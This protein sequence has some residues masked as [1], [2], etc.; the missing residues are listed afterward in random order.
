MKHSAIGIFLTLAP[1]LMNAQWKRT[2]GLPGGFVNGF[3]AAGDTIVTLTGQLYLTVDRGDNWMPLP[4]TPGDFASEVAYYEGE[5]LLKSYDHRQSE[6]YLWRSADFGVTWTFVQLADTMRAYHFFKLWDKIYTADNQGMF[7]TT[8][9]GTSWMQTT[10][11]PINQCTV[12]RNRITAYSFSSVIQSLDGGFEWDT[13]IQM[14]GVNIRSMIQ[15]GDT[16]L[17]FASLPAP[18]MWVTIDNGSTWNF[19]PNHQFSSLYDIFWHNQSLV[20]VSSNKMFRSFDLGASW[21]LEYEGLT[22]NPLYSGISAGG[23]T[24]LLGA[25][26]TGIQRRVG[27][28]KPWK[29]A[30]KGVN[31]AYPVAFFS[32]DS[33][34][35]AAFATGLWKLDQDGLNWNREPI[36]LPILLGHYMGAYDYIEQDG[37]KIIIYG[38]QIWVKPPGADWQLSIIEPTHSSSF[39]KLEYVSGGIVAF[40]NDWASRSSNRG[41][42]FSNIAPFFNQQY[43][44]GNNTWVDDNNLY[45]FDY[46]NKLFRSGNGGESWEYVTT[47][48]VEGQFPSPG[49]KP[50]AWIRKNTVLIKDGGVAARHVLFSP[51]LGLTW[52]Y[53]NLQTGD[54]P[55]GETRLWD[56]QECNGWLLLSTNNGIYVSNDSG[57]TWYDWSEG[58][59]SKLIG[60][61]LAH[62]GYVWAGLLKYGIWKRPV[63]E[64]NTVVNTDMP[65]LVVD[66][67][68]LYP[69]PGDGNTLYLT[70]PE[71]GIAQI[72]DNLGHLI[73]EKPVSEG[74]TRWDLPSLSLRPGSYFAVLLGQKQRYISL[75]MVTS[76]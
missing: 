67:L 58:L 9:N 37:Y 20:N 15:Q 49:P 74:I 17:L 36:D 34:L 41:L 68:A 32:S 43:L 28:N 22:G 63:S 24:I 48:P 30:N 31:N 3:T 33:A 59:D 76:G 61:I 35:Y 69:N 25:A 23:D 73:C 1:L 2:N 26:Y 38:G 60:P 45:L 14:P 71:A 65:E 55:W 12:D 40:A 70:A 16:I 75:F 5:I 44:I 50:T 46:A 56:L 4:S 13:L 27:S 66:H 57:L 62:D 11:L 54:K 10:K 19:Y 29:P 51:D 21:H 18:G 8:N 53:S 39:Y 7:L 42:S 64:L 6:P 47:A 52:H 72:W